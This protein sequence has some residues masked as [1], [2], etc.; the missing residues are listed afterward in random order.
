MSRAVLLPHAPSSVAI[1]RRCLREDLRARGVPRSLVEDAA[2]VL[3]ELVANALRHAAPLPPPHPPD[4]VRVA[5]SL[6]RSGETGHADGTGVEIAVSDGGGETLPRLAVPSPAADGCHGL[7]IVQR[8]SARWGTEVDESTTTVWAVI[9]VPV[10]AVSADRVPAFPAPPRP[11][12]SPRSVFA[13][14]NRET[15]GRCGTAKHRPAWVATPDAGTLQSRLW[16]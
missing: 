16:S 6:V 1:A 9:D 3:T 7:E 10:M 11:N 14:V 13:P 4:R 8:L 2:A 5:W 12:C 15:P